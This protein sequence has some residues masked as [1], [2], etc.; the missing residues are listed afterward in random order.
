M[1]QLDDVEDDYLDEGYARVVV[2]GMLRPLVLEVHLG[3]VAGRGGGAI[4]VA[5]AGVVECGG[6]APLPRPDHDAL[7]EVGAGK[8]ARELLLVPRPLLQHRSPLKFGLADFPFVLALTPLLLLPLHRLQHLRWQQ[9]DLAQF[10]AA[11]SQ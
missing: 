10:S 9:M 4:R 11:Y 5:V 7:M 1:V 3:V 6:D 2:D 8:E